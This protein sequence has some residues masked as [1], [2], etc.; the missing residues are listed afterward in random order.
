MNYFLYFVV[1]YFGA[2][3]GSFLNV[4][5]LRLPLGLSIAGRSRCVNCQHNLSPMEIF[6]LFSF[7]VLKRKCKYCKIPISWRYFIIELITGLLFVGVFFWQTPVYFTDYLFLLK[8]FALVVVLVAVFTI[9]LEHYL[10]LDS[11]LLV[12]GVLIFCL[13]LILDIAVQQK[14]YSLH[15]LTFSGLFAALSIFIFFYSLWFFSKGKWMGFGDVKFVFFLGIA[16]GW[17]NILICFL[18]SFLLGTIFSLPL[19]IWGK[20]TLSSKVPFGT[21]LSVAAVLALFWGNGLFNWY[22]ALLGF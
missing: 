15:S 17:P 5:I 2:I 6:P 21:F 4:A 18:L 1:F 10:I 19:L 14:I 20:K 11:V 12:G 13:N 8:N 9:D 22:V 3:A 7:L 16:L